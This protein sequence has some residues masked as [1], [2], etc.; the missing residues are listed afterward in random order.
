MKHIKLFENFEEKITLEKTL[1]DIVDLYIEEEMGGAVHI[2]EYLDEN[3][4]RDFASETT[5]EKISQYL[6]EIAQLVEDEAEGVSV[7]IIESNIDIE[8]ICN[9]IGINMED[10]YN[11]YQ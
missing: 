9:F 2:M 3:E 5:D 6:L 1:K 7:H 8:Y 10:K 4:L 11:E